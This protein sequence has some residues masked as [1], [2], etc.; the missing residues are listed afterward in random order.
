MMMQNGSLNRST[1]KQFEFQKNPRWQTAAILKTIKLPCLCNRS[2]DFD[3]IFH[4]DAYRFPEPDVKL[5]F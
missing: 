4:G 2:T 3:E 5:N 1:V